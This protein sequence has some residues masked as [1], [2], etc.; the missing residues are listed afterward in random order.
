MAHIASLSKEMNI[1][2]IPDELVY[3]SLLFAEGSKADA[4]TIRSRAA[5]NTLCDIIGV[6]TS[7]QA[8]T[9]AK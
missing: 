1:N 9:S 7:E 6:Q 2:M 3:T 8:I 4:G 5:E